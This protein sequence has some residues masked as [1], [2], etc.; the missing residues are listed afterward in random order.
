[1]ATR[2]RKQ[3][4]SRWRLLV[5]A[6]ALCCAPAPLVLLLRFV[7]PPFTALMLQ[8]PH[9]VHFRWV[10]W[11]QISPHV[12]VAIV[13]AEDQRFAEHYGFD[14]TAIARAAAH[15]E[16]RGAKTIRGAS[17]LSQQVAKNLFLWPGRSYIRKG[18]EAWLTL[19]IELLWPKQRILEVYLNVA[20]M[21]RGVFG[22]AAASHT[23]FGVPPKLLGPWQASRLAAV[24]PDPRGRSVTSPGR[25]TDQRARWIRGQVR[26]LGGTSYLR[27]L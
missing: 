3:R 19:W 24:L 11:E 23:Y 22:V 8:Q 5:W 15:N 26:H 27:S 6:L 16:K 18:L 9:K 4:N 10:P 1:V 21:G 13:A 17:T 25:Y 12:A 2:S 20:E 7:P 14:F